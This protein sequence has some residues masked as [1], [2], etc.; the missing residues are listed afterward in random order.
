MSTYRFEKLP[1]GA[2]YSIDGAIFPGVHPHNI[3]SAD[4]DDSV[5][6]T[7]VARLTR[8]TI[9]VDVDTVVIDETAIGGSLH[10]YGPNTLTAK[11]LQ[12]AIM[13]VFNPGSNYIMP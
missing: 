8:A 1:G 3:A 5:R 11:D 7:F 4:T 13:N 12:A 2:R 6:V 10:T 9:R